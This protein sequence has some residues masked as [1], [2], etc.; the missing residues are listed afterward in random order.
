MDKLALGC[1][2]V[3][4]DLHEYRV[5]D[6]KHPVALPLPVLKPPHGNQAVLLQRIPFVRMYLHRILAGFH[7]GVFVESA[8]ILKVV[9]FFE[10]SLD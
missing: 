6:F 3:D 2:A 5:V 4:R 10:S 8:T 7:S 1:F 9:V